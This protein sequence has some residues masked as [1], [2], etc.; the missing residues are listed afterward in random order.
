[1]GHSIDSTSHLPTW[2]D[3]KTIKSEKLSLRTYAELPAH[4]LE[5]GL[6][7]GQPANHGKMDLRQSF[8]NRV[9][10]IAFALPWVAS[11]LISWIPFTK[12]SISNAPGY[13]NLAALISTIEVLS[14]VAVF[15]C[16]SIRRDSLTDTEPSRGSTLKEKFFRSWFQFLFISPLV[17]GTMVVVMASDT[18]CDPEGDLDM[19]QPICQVGMR[20]I[21]ATGVC[22]AGIMYV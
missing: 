3:N 7:Q 18:S 14:I 16:T 15:I 2:Q 20:L 1:M 21:K 19:H 12:I 4:L 17:T 10:P 5:E 13:L 6:L 11:M 22:R 9:M 8:T